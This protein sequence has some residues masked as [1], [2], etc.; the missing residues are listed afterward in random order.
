MDEHSLNWRNISVKI[1][2]KRY[3]HNFK[4]KRTRSSIKATRNQSICFL[5]IMNNLLE[6]YDCQNKFSLSRLYSFFQTIRILSQIKEDAILS[7]IKSKYI[8]FFDLIIDCA[9]S[10]KLK[11][12]DYLNDL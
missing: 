3:F 2:D 10:L 5:L 7:N 1:K 11:R 9:F 12:K 6:L 8:L 4:I